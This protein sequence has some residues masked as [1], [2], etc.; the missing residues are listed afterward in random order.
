MF[1]RLSVV[2]LL[3]LASPAIAQE[4]RLQTGPDT[5]QSAVQLQARVHFQ[6]SGLVAHVQLEQEFR[7]DSGSWV[8]AEYLFP[9]PEDA[10]VNRLE[11]VIGERVIIGEIKEKQL[12]R[13]IYQQAKASGRKAGLVEQRRPNMFSS[14]IAN[15]APAETIK[16]KLEYVQRIAYS[17]GEFSLRFPMTLTPRYR[18]DADVWHFQNP[19]VA[20]AAAPIQPIT[21]TAELDMGLPLEAITATYHALAMTRQRQ[22]YKLTLA[23]GRVPMDRDFELR[24]RPQ[25]GREP[26]AALFHE[27][28]DGEDY[29]LLMVLPPSQTTTAG[30]SAQLARELVFVIDTSGSM[31][32]SSIRQARASLAFALDQ[33]RPGDA[34]NVI[35]FNNSAR[36]L[37]HTAMPVTDHNLGR[38]RE[39]VRHL[40]AVGGTEMMSALQLALPL[41]VRSERLRQVVFITDGAVGNEAALFREIQRRL[42]QSRLFT[43]GIGSAPNS[44][45]MRKAAEAGRGRFT[46]IGDVLEVQE[47]MQALFSQL[48]QTMLVDLEIDWPA[49][50]EMYPAKIPDLYPGEPVLVAARAD[51]A[52][53]NATVTVR[54]RSGGED[55][56]RSLSFAAPGKHHSG[57][58]T[59][60]A[61]KK[62]ASL[63]DEKQLGRDNESV[64]DAV[65]SVALK[66]QLIS[67]YTSFVAVEQQLSRPD[68]AALKKQPVPNVRPH[69]QSAQSYAWPR[70]ATPAAL[71]MLS[72]LLALLVAMF[73]LG[74]GGWIHL[75]AELAQVLIAR[76]WS[77]PPSASGS[78][79]WQ[80]AKPWPWADTYP[81]ARLQIPAHDVD[82]YVLAGQQGNALAFGPGHVSESALP[83]EAGTTIIAGHRDTHFDFIADLQ[84]GDRLSLTNSKQQQYH[85]QV[86]GHY[87]ADSDKQSLQDNDDD[88][89]LV[90]CYPFDAINPGGPLR[91]VVRAR[92]VL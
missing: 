83:G 87:V 54:G 66:H 7:N 28:V 26:Q 70:T 84:D 27:V 17:A 65:L 16:V 24:W 39:F 30:Q 3:T 22:L 74:S 78:G 91:Y 80:P 79:K 53:A 72:G 19:V 25:A 62:I 88:L 64:R 51:A 58:A 15:I 85:Y 11:L 10:A 40:D 32:G 55:W 60:W 13:E 61:R 76:A 68:E 29:A 23:D 34:F 12:A 5:Y 82:Q 92:Q 14:K 42:G 86:V 63:L 31:G 56:Q 77:A 71:Q 4:M 2:V 43:V 46:Y 73:Q 49:E 52:L 35:A 90:T 81:I 37:F 69:G 48:S 18:A 36:A 38:A 89:L 67:P 45:F 75:K 57:V 47:K 59:V 8:E 50:V 33:L 41:D 9:L 20:T 1:A 21:I 6:I 44:W